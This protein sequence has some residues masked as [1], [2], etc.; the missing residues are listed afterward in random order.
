MNTRGP[1][2]TVNARVDTRGSGYTHSIYPPE[3]TL[4]MFR[5]LHV[6]MHYS[7]VLP[8]VHLLA[9]LLS[10]RLSRHEA[11]PRLVSREYDDA[12][13][14]STSAQ[15]Y[16]RT[17]SLHPKGPRTCLQTTVNLHSKGPRTRLRTTSPPC[18]VFILRRPVYLVCICCRRL[19][20]HRTFFKQCMIP[21]TYL[22]VPYVYKYSRSSLML[23]LH[24]CT[25]FPDG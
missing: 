12:V 8:S 16:V 13:A 24:T 11:A 25:L 15:A 6:S 23:L 10:S 3:H 4:Q 9:G 1:G 20:I 17:V 14:T 18:T 21:G 7:V 19:L 22:F 5:D 2:Y